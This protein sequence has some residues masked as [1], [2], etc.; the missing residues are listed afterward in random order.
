MIDNSIIERSGMLPDWPV[1]KGELQR[2]FMRAL[3]H[4]LRQPNFT[5]DVV[6]SPVFE[7]HGTAMARA[8][9]IYEER[10]FNSASAERSIPMDAMKTE[11]IS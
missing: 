7:G 2:A 11:S 5:R 1:P 8:D 9:G 6:S 4:E 3:A 10:D